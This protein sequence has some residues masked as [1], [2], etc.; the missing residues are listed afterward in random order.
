MLLYTVTIESYILSFIDNSIQSPAFLSVK[1]VVDLFMLLD[2]IITFFTS[3]ERFDG[4]MECNL[5]KI[6]KHY[7][8]TYLLI[9]VIA[10]FP[11]WIL[12][13]GASAVSLSRMQL[14]QV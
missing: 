8:K 5:K 7:I 3:Y 2:I 6:S 11:T 12:D 4:P 10:C 9:D 1:L 13:L 14:K